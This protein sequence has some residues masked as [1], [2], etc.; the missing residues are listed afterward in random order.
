MSD[1][2]DYTAWAKRPPALNFR[3]HWE[4]AIVDLAEQRDE[5]FM[6]ILRSHIE[7]GVISSE[8]AKSIVSHG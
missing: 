2:H 7:A 1:Q 8:R 5:R 4:K 3:Q 6:K